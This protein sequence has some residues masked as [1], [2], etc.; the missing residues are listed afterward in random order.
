[1]PASFAKLKRSLKG[2]I[3]SLGSSRMDASSA[4]MN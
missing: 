2:G 4:T 1:M 3:K